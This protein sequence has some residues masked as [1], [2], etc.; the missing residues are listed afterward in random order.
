M[1]SAIT[2]LVTLSLPLVVSSVPFSEHHTIKAQECKAAATAEMMLEL[3]LDPA[4]LIERL[5]IKHK[6][7]PCEKLTYDQVDQWIDDEI[8]EKALICVYSVAI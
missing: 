4:T 3:M 2:F 1:K 7:N 8:A 6:V 5:C